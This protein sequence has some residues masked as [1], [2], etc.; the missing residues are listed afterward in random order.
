MR[1]RPFT[2]GGT[3]LTLALTI[4]A[5]G[6]GTAG[7]V[8]D[9]RVP[10]VPGVQVP[11]PGN[12]PAPVRDV[13]GTVNGVAGGA[14]D[15]VN[16][17]VDT[18]NNVTQDPVGTINNVTQDPVGT[19]TGPSGPVGGVTGGGN[20]VGGG[21]GGSQT[22]APSSDGGGSPGGG[23]TGAGGSPG[24][25][26]GGA[27]APSAGGG[28]AQSGSSGG[29]DRGGRERSGGGGRGSDARGDGAAGA[30]GAGGGAAARA[31]RLRADRAASPE[32]DDEP[33][34]PISRVIDT[35]DRILPTPIKALIAILALLALGF[36]VHS[37]IVTGRARRLE[38]QREEL[39]GDVGLL[40]RALLPDVP[41]DLRGIDV[42]VAYRPA[43][44][45]AAGGDFYDVFELD[46]GR[47]AIIVGD[48]CGHGR[49]AL[50]V[51]ALM[52]YTLRAYLGVGFEPRLALQVAARA[53]DATPD[54]TLT[55]VVLAIYDAEAGTLTY[56]CAGHEPPI[57]LGP[58]E[59]EPVTAFSAPPLGGS[60]ATGQR[61]TTVALPEGSSVCFF[62]DGL[63]EARLG[64]QMIGR[65][66][67]SEILSELEPGCGAQLLLERL[68]AAADRAPDDMAACLVRTREGGSASEPVRVEEL[69]VTADDLRGERVDEFLAA[70]TVPAEAAV[71]ALRAARAQ[72]SEFGAALLRVSIAGGGATVEVSPKEAPALPEPSLDAARRQAALEVPTA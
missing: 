59:Y 39:L 64:D 3:A 19:V 34:N 37:R 35:I 60:M 65:L 49:A 38:R 36:A 12:L 52:R 32:A 10:H 24:G 68:A 53:L 20:P 41:G 72:A 46:G 21:S 14:T 54:S 45:P 13:V 56:A 6:T 51:T 1:A 15:T 11:V 8:I 71:D 47:T 30:A 42:S 66:R 26:G 43:E 70:C 9:V 5:A 22:P 23:D 61:Q 44:G 57:V 7:A 69:E 25:G 55:T 2:R 48:V 67:L 63:V 29:G 18:V 28:G 50:A 62:T 4:L 16:G 27:D 40:Q 31:A 17:A 58:A 33:S